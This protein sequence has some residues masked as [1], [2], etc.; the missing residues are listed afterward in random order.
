MVSLPNHIS[1][2]SECM[3]KAFDSMNNGNLPYGDLMNLT[4]MPNIS[5]INLGDLSEQIPKRQ[6]IKKKKQAEEAKP[7]FSVKDI[8]APHKIK[9]SL[10][11]YI[12]LRLKSPTCS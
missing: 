1:I 5:M 2:C 6:K 9:A 12:I 11:E 3:Q 7:Q 10:D 4:N 8:P